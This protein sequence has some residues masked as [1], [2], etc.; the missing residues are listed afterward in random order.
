MNAPDYR[1][2]RGMCRQNIKPAALTH[3]GILSLMRGSLGGLPLRAALKRG[4]LITAANWPVVFIQ[5]MMVSVHR[6]A[7]AVPVVGGI[8]VV[9]VL[10]GA[11]VRALLAADLRAAI[12]LVATALAGRPEALATFLVAVGL[13]AVGGSA[14]VFLA[15]AGIC[16]ILTCGER[17]A[18]PLHRGPLRLGAM[19]GAAVYGIAGF[20]EGIRR[21]GRRF[22]LLGAWLCVAYTVLLALTMVTL[23]GVATASEGRS[24]GS[25]W[26][27]AALL[28]TA[29]AAIGLAALNLVYAL[30]Q[31]IVTT[32]DCRVSQAVVRLHAFVT[33]DARRVAGVFGVVLALVL[34]AWAASILATAGLALVAWVPV[35]GLAVVPLQLAAWLLRGLVFHYMELGAWSAYQSQ[36]R[37]YV[38]PALEEPPAAWVSRA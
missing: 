27:I 8:F 26:G 35:V 38:D 28:V 32:D 37:R 24:W 25:F 12:G 14:I 13:V 19:R 4:A 21:Y 10:A 18:G 17:Q 11:D 20:F 29:G 22:L 7:M 6:L 9:A 15:Q 1:G 5:F 23:W 34:L 2:R 30:V 31:V 36:Y 16:H 3:T 33:H